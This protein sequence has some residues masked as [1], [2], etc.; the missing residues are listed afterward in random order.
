[1]TSRQPWNTHQ[2]EF[3]S[4]KYYVKEEI[5]A[6]NGSSIGIE[7]HQS[8]EYY[9]RKIVDEED[10]IFNIQRFNQRLVDSVQ[11]SGKWAILIEIATR[12]KQLQL[13][14]MVTE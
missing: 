12:E 9:K 7:F 3:P 4:T 11:I 2:I 13:D 5:E 8:I 6:Q 1:M 14:K 10:I